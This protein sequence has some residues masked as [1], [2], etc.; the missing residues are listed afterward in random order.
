[1]KNSDTEMD[2]CTRIGT[3]SGRL[4]SL[5]PHF[6]RVF[7]PLLLFA[8]VASTVLMVLENRHVRELLYVEQE[9]QVAL[10]LAS[11][12]LDIAG[13]IQELL[14]LSRS[15]SLRRF[16]NGQGGE[17][18]TRDIAAFA[19]Q[20]GRYDQVR[21]LDR[22][23][24]ERLRIEYRDGE[25]RILPEAQL[26]DKSKR[27]YFTEGM[28]L[29]IGSVYLSPLDLNI[30]HNRIERP[31]RPML[32]V[33]TPTV[34]EG[35]RPD[36]LLVFNYQASQ[37][38]Q[39][40]AASRQ[41]RDTEIYLLNSEGYWLYNRDSERQWGFMFGLD[42][43]FQNEHPDV[44]Q[45]M[46][47]Q[48][49]GT[50]EKPEGR[51]V[52]ARMR[53]QA[54]ANKH[55][56]M[57]STQKHQR[58]WFVVS[59][60]PVTSQMQHYRENAISY[61]TLAA[62]VVLVLA[63]VS[64]LLARTTCEKHQLQDRLALHAKVMATATNGVMITD[65]ESRILDV[66]DAFT[67]LTGYRREEVLGR[68]PAILSSGRHDASFYGEMWRRIKETGF[69]EGEIWNRHKS[70]EL[71][72]EWLSISAVR[73]HLG[74]ITHYIAIFSLLSEQKSTEKRLRQL[75]NS[76][77][78]TGLL[79]RNL[80]Y[81]RA[82]QAMAQSRRSNTRTAFLFLDLD[83]F[84]PI[85]DALGHAAGDTVLKT[86]ATR[87]SGSVRESDTVARYGGD[88]FV[89]LLSG[90]R[91]QSEAQE[92]AQKILQRIAEPMLIDGNEVR[93]GCSIGISFFPDDGDSVEV[94]LKH[95]DQ[96]MYQAKARGKGNVAFYRA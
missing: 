66:N 70:G 31:Y 16:I 75:A 50:L 37:L 63:L 82:G 5:L 62:A 84:K 65:T 77:T 13:L 83:G 20:M 60:Y 34:G 36:G 12:Q 80:L 41:S 55:V 26:Q 15:D 53:P 48:E 43:R 8:L 4:R 51:F 42:K 1:M 25:L 29:D 30:E 7:L 89:V 2:V 90:L 54:Y 19:E 73:D 56:V 17:A 27:Y 47:Q 72:P 32:R 81:D 22:E 45:A 52:F 57:G 92:V 74:R 46:Q 58:A 33:A 38:L 40:F 21:W 96:A 10:S 3:S 49:Y 91:V 23:G 14:Y 86:V 94:L 11:L 87:L 79:N 18:A 24:M 71:F 44:W 39:N 9:Q 93:V 85:N 76:D 88:E 6:L 64:A 78:L 67:S 59:F 68:T 95:A 35:G 28:A 69:W 61:G